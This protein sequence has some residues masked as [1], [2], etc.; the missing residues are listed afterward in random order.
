MDPLTALRQQAARRALAAAASSHNA[1]SDVGKDEAPLVAAS[2]LVSA[3][4][5]LTAARELF[6]YD[7]DKTG[8]ISAKTLRLLQPCA[9]QAALAVFVKPTAITPGQYRG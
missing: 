3:A 4:S 1:S 2:H 5:D 9:R 8:E 7:K 6:Q